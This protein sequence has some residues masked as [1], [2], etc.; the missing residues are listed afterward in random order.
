M[1]SNSFISGVF[2]IRNHLGGGEGGTHC[3]ICLQLK[4]VKFKVTKY[5]SGWKTHVPV[6]LQVWME[7]QPTAVSPGAPPV[8]S[9]CDPEP[10]ELVDI[11]NG[12]ALIH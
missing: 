5:Q 2:C 4:L 12:P 9:F 8:N 6:E 7:T 1:N 10:R 11:Q 3:T